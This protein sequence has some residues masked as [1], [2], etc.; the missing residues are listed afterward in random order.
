[1]IGCDDD[2]GFKVAGHIS[3]DANVSIG[4]SLGMECERSENGMLI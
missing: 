1:M 4:P 3:L 2:R